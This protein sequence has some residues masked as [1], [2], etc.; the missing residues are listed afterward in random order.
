MPIID[1]PNELRVLFTER[2]QQLKDHAGQISFPGGRMERVDK[3]LADT[4]LRETVEETGLAI[5]QMEI[6]GTLTPVIS[7][8]GF[9]VTPFI[10]FVTPPLQLNLDP[11]EVAAAFTTPLNYVLDKA[12]HKTQTILEIFSPYYSANKLNS[13]ICI[14]CQ[15]L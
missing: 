9:L 14:V 2:T 13:H 1:D 5:D 3:N 12:H 11:T 10:G 8:T 4:A 6:I 7:T 15:P